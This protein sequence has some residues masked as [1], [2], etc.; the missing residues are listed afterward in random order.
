M[1]PDAP[2]SL[3][4]AH[5]LQYTYKRSLGHVL[6]A[7]FTGLRDGKI[8]GVRT[9]DGRVLVPPKEYDPQSAAPLSEMVEVG[10]AG[11]VQSWAWVSR[12]REKQPLAHPFAYALIQLDGADTPLLHAVDAG[13][14]SKMRT[15]MRV[16]ARFASETVGAI[17]DIAC[18][19][20]E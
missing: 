17:T 16:R 20:P 19:E 4:A 18:F 3:T 1:P 11:V 13:S 10:R 12:P 5:T 9:A 14:E 8:L 2:H 7:F 6:S 15:G